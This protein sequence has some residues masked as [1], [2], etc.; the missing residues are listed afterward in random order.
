MYMAI[1]A[2]QG[3]SDDVDHSG[4]LPYSQGLQHSIGGGSA[5]S[6]DRAADSVVARYLSFESGR[7]KG[8]EREGLDGYKSLCEILS[9]SWP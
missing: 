5:C 9:P 8:G 6:H 3:G 7:E 1:G 2:E 4:M